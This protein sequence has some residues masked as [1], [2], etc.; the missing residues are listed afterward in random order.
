MIDYGLARMPD[1]ISWERFIAVVLFDEESSIISKNNIGG[2]PLGNIGK[3]TARDHEMHCQH[4]QIV[5]LYHPHWH[6]GSQSFQNMN[7][8]ICSGRSF[9]LDVYIGLMHVLTRKYTA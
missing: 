6:H 8:M 5:W 2:G 4:R 9:K 1:G 7:P 3:I